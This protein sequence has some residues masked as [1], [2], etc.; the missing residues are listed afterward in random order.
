MN[1]PVA[2]K[3]PPTPQRVL[4]QF[5]ATNV[6]VG[7][8]IGVGIFFNPTRVAE[9]A[10]SGGLALAAWALAGAIA[11]CG[12]LT[13]AE[14]GSRYFASGAQYEVLRDAYGTGAGFCFVLCNA[15]AIQAGAIAAI[16]L[17][18][19]E[20]IAV[21]VKADP[22][23]GWLHAGLAALLT[24]GI[25]GANI[26]GVRWGARIQNLTVV[27][28]VLTI[29]AI[30]LL[31]L[32]A[33]SGPEPL[34][35]ARSP[36]GALEGVLAALLPAF[37]AYGGWQHALWIAGEIR[38]PARNV[39]RAIIA[40]TVIVV[41][42]YLLANVAYLRLLG[43]EGVKASHTVAADAVGAVL[44]SV[45]RQI[46]AAA[47]AVSA[48][49]V[50][51]A[52]LLSGPRLLFGIARDGRFFVPL[53][54][55]HRR[56]GTPARAIAL[57]SIM[58]I[59]LLALS[60]AA[61]Q[62]HV[63]RREVDLILA[64]SVTIDGVFFA[65]TGAALIILRRKG[66]FPGGEGFRTPGYPMVPLLFV[67]GTACMVVG[68]FFAAD[69]RDATIFGIAWIAAAVAFYAIAAAVKNLRRPSDQ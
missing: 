69:S 42:V 15:T 65:L 31:A 62:L 29:V 14:L 26:V 48:F 5:D 12:A 11:L 40:G 7:A 49:G 19:V 2:P 20:Y 56:F 59:A 45:G 18:C 6:V 10:G 23:T 60:T 4:N 54:D 3:R 32:F 24:L 25:T 52:Q 35:S 13:F 38:D 47:V 58:G 22:P 36:A 55:V 50:L 53:G 16:A 27:A 21:A 43:Y 30:T 34:R 61:T 66:L 41:V 28:K 1:A 57:L 37:F 44:P 67:I 51:N 33:S 9:L 8:I 46:L 39:P 64:C 68:A 17:I 63:G